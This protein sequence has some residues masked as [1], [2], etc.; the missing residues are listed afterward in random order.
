MQIIPVGVE[1]NNGTPTGTSSPWRVY[2]HIKWVCMCRPM[3]KRRWLTKLIKLKVG[4]FRADRTLKVVPLEL[5]E[6]GKMG[7]FRKSGCF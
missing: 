1:R 7:A 3:L 4:A 6:L 2:S 5:I